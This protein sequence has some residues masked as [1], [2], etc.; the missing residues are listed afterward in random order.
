MSPRISDGCIDTNCISDCTLLLNITYLVKNI[1]LM[2]VGCLPF[3]VKIT[4]TNVKIAQAE[5]LY[6]FEVFFRV[7][8]FSEPFERAALG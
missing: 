1:L 5:Q 3:I 8:G 7:C 2:P 6:S 4:V